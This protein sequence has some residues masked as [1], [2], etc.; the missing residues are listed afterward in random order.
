MQAV[1]LSF[2]PC[3]TVF[4]REL[5]ETHTHTPEQLA[6]EGSSQVLH[7]DL[8]P[9]K[10]HIY[11]YIHSI[12]TMTIRN[13]QNCRSALN[14]LAFTKKPT[15][16]YVI[17][18]RCQEPVFSHASWHVLFHVSTEDHWN[19]IPLQSDTNQVYHVTSWQ[20][21]ECCN[22]HWQWR[23]CIGRSQDS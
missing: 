15:N 21:S 3:D 13:L 19:S 4:C 18:S 5:T 8:E 10:R 11:I 16:I 23:T 2:A 9:G 12:Y 20:L 22:V 7:A 14:N 1:V 17:S 6:G